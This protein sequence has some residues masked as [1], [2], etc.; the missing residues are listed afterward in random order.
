MKA[1]FRHILIHFHIADRSN[2]WEW[3]R[4]L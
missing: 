2:V 4:Y 3:T 1:I